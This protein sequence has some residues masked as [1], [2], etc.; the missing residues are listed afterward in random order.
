MESGSESA[1]YAVPKL[2][3]H[4]LSFMV[5]FNRPGEAGAVLETTSSLI[6]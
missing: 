5:I 1:T 4:V 3:L 2:L 6:N